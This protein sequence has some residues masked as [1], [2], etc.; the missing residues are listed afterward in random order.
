MAMSNDEIYSPNRTRSRPPF[1]GAQAHG[2]VID[3]DG[4]EIPEAGLHPQFEG[5]RFA[6]GTSSANPFGKLT[7][8]QR[9]ARLDAR[10]KFPDAALTPPATK[11]RY[12]TDGIIGVVPVTGVPSISALSPGRGQRART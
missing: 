7:R 2:K 12:G 9:L 1:G 11:I 4:R 6:F 3:Q 8:Q 10:A 5:F